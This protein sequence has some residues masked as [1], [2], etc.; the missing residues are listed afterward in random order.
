MAFLLLLVMLTTCAAIPQ[1]LSGKMFTFPEETGTANVRLKTSTQDFKAV[2]VCFRSITDLRRDHNLFSLATPSAQNAF[3]IF[4]TASSVI[5]F[6]VSNKKVEFGAEDYKL[7]MWHSFCSTWDSKTGLV[8]LWFDGKSSI[9][10]FTGGSNITTP[11][12]ILGQ[13]QDSFGGGFDVKQSF[14]GMMSDVHMW[15]YTLSSCEIE[16]YMDDLNFTP[17]NALNWRALDFQITERVLIEDKQMS[18]H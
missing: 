18:C 9:R 6:L 8:Q 14:V 17:G 12:V 1:D 7:N 4:K 11:S 5:D 16:R 2:T 13:E 10:K 15:D 3:L